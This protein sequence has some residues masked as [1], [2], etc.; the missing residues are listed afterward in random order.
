[1]EF[2]TIDVARREALGSSNAIRQRRADLIPGV[3]CGMKRP[4][5]E[6]SIAR[7]EIQRFL[8]TGSHLVEL[9]MGDQTRP[10]ILREMQTDALTD[11]I[12]HVDF[13]RVDDAHEVETDVPLAFKGRA[14]GEVDGGVFAAVQDRVSVKA[15]PRALP[16]SYLVDI[17]N[18]GLDDTITAADLLQIEGV[19]V[20]HPAHAVLATCHVPRVAVEKPD[21]DE[22][23]QGSVAP[24]PAAE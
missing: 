19:T 8:R 22:A 13:V 6:L 11:R 23:D 2:I 21:E 7:T 14:K 15:K 10:A 18:M 9:K 5:I 20:M 24:T 1:M 3:L 17:S 16:R 4:N 12:L